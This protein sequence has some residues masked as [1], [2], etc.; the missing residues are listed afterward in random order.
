MRIMLDTN[1][2]ISSIIFKSK[3]MNEM[4]AAILKKHRLVLS[5]FVI[6]ELKSV[7]QR[8]FEGKS[9]DLDLFLTVLPFEYV[10]TP[11]EMDED[12]FEIRDEMDYPVLY[13]AI[14]EDVDILITGDKD[15]SDVDVEKP[16]ILTP[17][18]FLEKYVR[19][20]VN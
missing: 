15:F 10:Y 17:Q 4:I 6:E 11:D 19:T 1:V 2:L 12:L 8:K 14:V 20:D 7:V 13:S 9:A 16:E 3:I 18:E 5:S